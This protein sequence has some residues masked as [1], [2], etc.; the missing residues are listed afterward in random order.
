M[1]PDRKSRSRSVFA[2]GVASAS[3]L[4]I[5]LAKSLHGSSHADIVTSE[6]SCS[7]DL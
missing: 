2:V 7:T 1:I 5:E 3:G 6:N 4:L